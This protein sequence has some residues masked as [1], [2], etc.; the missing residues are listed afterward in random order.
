[1]RD[2]GRESHENYGREAA[3]QRQNAYLTVYL[4]LCLS[5]ILSLFLTLLD[6]V[7]RNGARLEAECVTDIGLQS[8]LAEYH[9]ELMK[10]YNLFAI[11][12]SYGTAA[13]GK[14]NTEAHLLKYLSRNVSYDDI[15]LSDY[16]YR[17]FF[18]LTVE[19]AE[20]TKGSILTDYQGAVFRDSAVDAVKDDIGLDLLQSLQD[21]MQK[22]EVNGLEEGKEETKKE[23]LDKEIEEWVEAYDGTQ[24]EVEEGRW[25]TVEIE[26]PTDELESQ[27]SKGILRLVI[28]SETDLSPNTLN[29]ENLIMDR[30]QKGQVN[31]GN[32]EREEGTQAQ[33][34]TERFLF[35]EY[36]LRY[37]GRYGMEH[38]E[39]ALRYQ[40]E[41]LIAGKDSDVE[42]LRSVANRLCV[43]R[44]AAN[45]MYLMSDETKKNEIR[46]AAAALCALI[47]QPGLAPLMEG[48]I[49][50]A[51]AYAESIY[52]VKS[53]LSGGRIPLLKDSGSWHYSLTAALEGGLRDQATEGDGLC[54]QD[55]LRIFMMLTDQDT[56]TARAMNMVEADIRKT[57]GNA[58]FRLD[59]CYGAV[60]A[61]I[62]IGS[63]YG[64][65]YEITR[66]KSYR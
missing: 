47:L 57:P 15:F 62:R 45:A 11:D 33:E 41:Y 59:G 22:V 48:A 13:C 38:E 29:T 4:A 65:Q 2:R 40:I 52:D 54:Y 8:I 10:Q 19:R 28:G 53:L 39:D 61:Y 27:K 9:R 20:L 64:F 12:S 49:L 26:N 50:L 30:M 44:E 58:A 42:N 60:E 31:R 21:W 6:G 24:V 46:I 16:L 37:M 55:Y 35:Q 63:A 5:V 23:E 14:S 18:A 25:E 1:M 32:M 3:G 36:L 17:D 56:I 66:Q 43:L 51:W 34:L 7:R